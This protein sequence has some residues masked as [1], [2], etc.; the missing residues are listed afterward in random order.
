MSDP[1]RATIDRL[2][3]ATQ[4]LC[5]DVTTLLLS[6]HDLHRH[7]GPVGET[8]SSTGSEVI[9]VATNTACRKAATGQAGHIVVSVPVQTS[10]VPVEQP[11]RMDYVKAGSL[12][13]TDHPATPPQEVPAATDHIEVAISPTLPVGTYIGCVKAATVSRPFVI[14]LDGL[15]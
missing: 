13:I 2:L 9:G 6:H 5:H 1:R 4:R 14:Y 11:L 15:P 7:D 10:K 12:T 8:K 3:D